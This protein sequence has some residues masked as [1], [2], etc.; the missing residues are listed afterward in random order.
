MI[1]LVPFDELIH[2]E[3]RRDGEGADV[4]AQP[5]LDRRDEVGER[6]VGLLAAVGL[7][8]EHREDDPVVEHEVVALVTAGQNP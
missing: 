5:R 7:L 3:T 2:P 4:V 8:A 6:S 1:G